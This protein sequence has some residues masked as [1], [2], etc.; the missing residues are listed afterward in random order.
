V[1]GTNVYFRADQFQNLVGGA[2]N[3]I[4]V[5]PDTSNTWIITGAN[6]GTLNGAVSFAGM[7]NLVGNT[8]YDYF[9]ISAGAGLS[10]FLWDQGGNALIDYSSF[11]TGVYVNLATSQAT[12]IAGGIFNVP[13]VI[14]GAGNDILVGNHLTNYLD[15]GPGRDL[16]IGGGIN[17]AT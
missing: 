11:T 15:G 2:S 4:L 1:L 13:Y 5:G 10:G 3:D 16:I 7:E 17:W 14:G 9:A 8:G 6:A 12:N